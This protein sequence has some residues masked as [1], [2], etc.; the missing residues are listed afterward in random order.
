MTDKPEQAAL[1]SEQ[2]KGQKAK[3]MPQYREMSPAKLQ[4]ILEQNG[5]WVETEGKDGKQ[6]TLDNANL[7]EAYLVQAN[8]QEADLRGANHARA[9]NLTQTQLNQSCVDGETILPE[10]LTRPKPC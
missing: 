10:G 1:T 5:K 7:R 6:A 3:K 9:L 8:L 4:E 2:T